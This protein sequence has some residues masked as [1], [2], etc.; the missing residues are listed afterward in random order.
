[1]EKKGNGNGPVVDRLEIAMIAIEVVSALSN[2]S[3]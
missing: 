1:M 3:A 2:V